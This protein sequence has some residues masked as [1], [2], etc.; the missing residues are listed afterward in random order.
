MLDS[1]TGY[2]AG[3]G[4]G[5]QLRRPYFLGPSAKPP[6]DTGYSEWE[7]HP[8]DSWG[9][10]RAGRKEGRPLIQ[11]ACPSCAST[12]TVEDKFSGRK[13]K[14]PK[15]GARVIHVRDSK[16]ELLTAGTAPAA[17]PPPPASIP[18][19]GPPPAAPLDDA[20]P[21]ATAVVPQLVGEFVRQS[22]SKQNVLIV[23]GLL[24]VF[25]ASLSFLGILIDKPLLV[26]SPIAVAL[27]AAAA[28][29]WRKKRKLEQKLAATARHASKPKP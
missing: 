20:T 16:V 22:E 10:P 12:C 25:A 26:V 19:G 17:P 8:W 7:A 27:V 14:C 3:R 6:P 1:S 9:A 11:F 18:A 15:C 13:I 5:K 23:G 21:V 29:I 24:G 2:A 28:W 4:P